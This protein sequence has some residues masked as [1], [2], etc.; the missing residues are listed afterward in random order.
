MSGNLERN[1]HTYMH[2]TTY[3]LAGQLEDNILAS[4]TRSE[5]AQRV[6]EK[7]KV[8]Q[9]KAIIREEAETRVG[10]AS[11]LAKCIARGAVQIIQEG[12]RGVDLKTWCR[13][14]EKHSERQTLL[15]RTGCLPG[16]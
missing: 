15:N 11:N 5:Q 3:M 2:V 1:L 6:D 9:G 10:G 7:R 12:G 14:P 16:F 4:Y 13:Y 8:W